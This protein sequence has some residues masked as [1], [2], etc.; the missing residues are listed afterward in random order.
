MLRRGAD[1]L[2][3]FLALNSPSGIHAVDH[4]KIEGYS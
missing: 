4:T 1:Y 2:Y 3:A